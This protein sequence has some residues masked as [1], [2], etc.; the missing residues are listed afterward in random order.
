METCTICFGT[1]LQ[2]N[3][4][5]LASHKYIH[6]M[7]INR[8]IIEFSIWMFETSNQTQFIDF[9]ANQWFWLMTIVCKLRIEIV[10]KVFSWKNPKTILWIYSKCDT[11]ALAKPNHQF[12]VQSTCS[13][14]NGTSYIL[15]F[16]TLLHS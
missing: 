13:K 9:W 6:I 16:K 10:F 14:A 2:L 8:Y 4:F 7:Y 15:T 11:H 1:K 5:G 12:Y 3:W